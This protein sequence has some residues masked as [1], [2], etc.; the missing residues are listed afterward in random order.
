MLRGGLMPGVW[1][2]RFVW[3]KI[4]LFF[5]SRRVHTRWPR[6]WSSDMCSSDLFGKVMR[7]L[8][9]AGEQLALPRLIDDLVTLTGYETYLKDGTEEGEERWANVQELRTLAEDYIARSEEHTSELQSRGHLVCR[10]LLEK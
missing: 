9:T 10:L 4:Q 8:R 6:D 3:L 2:A 5:S 1:I 7:R